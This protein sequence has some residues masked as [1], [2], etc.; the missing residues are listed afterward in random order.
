MPEELDH[1]SKVAFSAVKDM[2]QTQG[3]TYLR[4]YIQKRIDSD[5]E[6]LTSSDASN[7]SR[8][9]LLQGEIK[10]LKDIIGYVGKREKG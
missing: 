6:E 2:T 8:I 3:W 5:L 9:A 4:E 1:R 7:V 10:G